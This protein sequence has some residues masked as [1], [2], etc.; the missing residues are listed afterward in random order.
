MSE[1]YVVSEGR[2]LTDIYKGIETVWIH[3][4]DGTTEVRQEMTGPIFV[5]AIPDWYWA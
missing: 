2:M 3:W 4:S 5:P 1:R